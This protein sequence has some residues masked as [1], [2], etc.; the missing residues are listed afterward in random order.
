MEAAGGAESERKAARDVGA[1]QPVADA[2][3][4]LV[5][6]EATGEAAAKE[7]QAARPVAGK[8]ALNATAAPTAGGAGIAGVEQA[9][10]AGKLPPPEAV[11]AADFLRRFGAEPAAAETHRAVAEAAPSPFRHGV[12]L[13]RVVVPP[14]KAGLLSRMTGG[15]G[16][17]EARVADKPAGDAGRE[18]LRVEVN[19]DAVPG[20]RVVTTDDVVA[21]GTSRAD[22]LEGTSHVSLSPGAIALFEL[23]P[24]TRAMHTAEGADL[25]RVVAAKGKVAADEQVGDALSIADVLKGTGDGSPRLLVTAC[26]VEFAD[27]LRAAA[28][29]RATRLARILPVLEPVV[30]ANAGDTSAA[31]LLDWVRR[32]QAI[33]AAVQQ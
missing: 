15:A 3:Q 14:A 17:A 16:K 1:R 28:E 24:G 4:G 26:A 7:A 21:V 23:E 20:Y 11:H 8:I 25:G 12:T 2:A 29:E 9:L 6:A 5:L 32:A 33:V 22:R 27:A 19:P 18:R 10:A 30:K 31:E 13:V